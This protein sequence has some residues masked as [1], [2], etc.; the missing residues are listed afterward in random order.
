MAWRD[1]LRRRAAGPIAAGP[2][3]PAERAGA[4]AGGPSGEDPHRSVPEAPV[5]A[6][7][8]DWDGGWRRTPAPVLTVSRTPLGVSDGLAFRA[9]LAAWQN[10]SFDS[11]LGH[12][13]LPTAPAGLVR[14]VTRPAAPHAT[15]TGGGPLL[16]RSL[17]PE[18]TDGPQ[19][20]A[21]GTGAPDA[22]APVG[23]APVG[24]VRP[25]A[26]RARP[27]AQ[28]SGSASSGS[29]SSDSASSGRMPSGRMPSG[30]VSSGPVS[31]GEPVVARPGSDG[32]AA[33]KGRPDEGPQR[34]GLTSADSPAV[35]SASPSSSPPAVQRAAMPGTGP[36]VPSAGTG[37]RPATPEIPL[38][39][40]VSVVPGA[41]ADRAT[42]RPGSDGP[43]ST[44]RSGLPE[45]DPGRASR[46]PSGTGR[47]TTPGPDGRRTA[48][49]TTG[50]RPDREGGAPEASPDSGADVSHPAVRLRP[51]GPSLTVARRPAGPVRRVPALRPATVEDPGAPST[52]TAPAGTRPAGT[53][54]RSTTPGQGAA[55]RAPLGAPLSELP[56]TATPLTEDAPAPHP[57]PGAK[58]ASGPVL[59]LVQRRVEGATGTEGSY[60][61]AASRTA[62][63][64][65]DGPAAPAGTP[66]RPPARTGA[67]ARG[68]LGAPLPALPPS[69]GLPDATA[70]GPDG[71]RAPV[72]RDREA[73]V[74]PVP[75]TTDRERTP[76][77]RVSRATGDNGADAPLLGTGD[78]QRRLAAG[79]SGADASKRGPAQNG[80]GP[81]TPLV[82]SSPATAPQGPVPEAAADEAGPARNARRPGTASGGGPGSDGQRHRVPAAP[83]PLV[84]ARRAA[85]GTAGTSGA[86]S[87]GPGALPVTRSAAHS[88]PAAPRTLSLLAARPLSLNT[89]PPEGAAPPAARTGSRPV[90]AAR[91]PA[92]TAAARTDPAQSSASRAGAPVAARTAPAQPP[93]SR[94]GIPAATGIAPA[95]PPA[96]RSGAPAATGAVPAQPPA[97]P[98]DSDAP[99]APRDY[100]VPPARGPARPTPGGPAGAPANPPIQ[101]AAAG[102]RGP[103]DPGVRPTGS[104]ASVQRV[105]VVR[106]APSHPETPGPGALPPSAAVPARPLPVTAP[107]AP[108]L[109]D[110]PPATPAPATAGTAPVVRRKSAGPGGASGATATS[111]QRTGSG[112]GDRVS[113]SV[114]A[115]AGPARGGPRPASAS[116]TTS[117]SGKGAAR[118]AESAPDPGLDLDDL[119]RRLLDPV[120]RLLRAELR[121]GR[122]RTGRPHDGRR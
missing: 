113:P 22:G 74:A 79:S 14:G 30:P 34:R 110:R 2:S 52:T 72:R 115:E 61:G 3:R 44:T 49:G 112:A 47:R 101:R 69:A 92:T 93:A 31:S 76:A 104:A 29:A 9:G 122:E 98:F 46:P 91:W 106:P 75:P 56:A 13:L 121:R 90:V 116:A 118:R 83:G 57:T 59:P 7:P 65:P 84:V 50:P 12:A 1:R 25:S 71:R 100:P 37:R 43:A 64:T 6:V 55:P 19:D 11:G 109:A 85:E 81:V 77:E 117:A 4:E 45:P 5:P 70:S 21:S 33:G 103:E 114:P 17:R 80:N 95:Q 102:H 38:V 40:R 28:R 105:P 86:R 62:H 78:V 82:A 54:A 89:R 66:H 60:D 48:T 107:Q 18:G 68:G 8:G 111:V 27:G 26:G 67:R 20:G 23:G 39:R 35:L 36:V 96:S 16:L 15:R 73:H 10:P 32:A 53:R 42:A 120:A 119:A 94:S 41:A 108:P 99:A 97:T 88:A 24:A 63:G 87:L 58:A 51:A